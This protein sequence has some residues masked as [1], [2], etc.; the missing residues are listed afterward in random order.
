MP[1]PPPKRQSPLRSPRSWRPAWPIRSQ[2]IEIRLRHSRAVAS[3]RLC[4]ARRCLV[5]RTRA[6][7]SAATKPRRS[8][9]LLRVGP[10]NQGIGND[11]EHARLGAI[12][13]PRRPRARVTETDLALKRTARTLTRRSG[14]RAREPFA[15]EPSTDKF[16][17]SFQKSLLATKGR[18]FLRVP[19]SARLKTSGNSQEPRSNHKN[20]KVC[21]VTNSLQIA[22]LRR[23]HFFSSCAFG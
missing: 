20:L 21:S 3:A 11:V 17:K 10:E 12:L 8:R 15:R 14:D 23:V 13:K 16:S 4:R 2:T 22:L 9:V 7:F 5:D 1:G 6:A 18:Q 19:T